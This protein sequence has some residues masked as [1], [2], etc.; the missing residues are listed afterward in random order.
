M[1][2]VLGLFVAWGICWILHLISDVLDYKV[3]SIQEARLNKKSTEKYNK[4][5][6]E[7]LNL[8][9]K[10]LEELDRLARAFADRVTLPTNDMSAEMQKQLWNSNYMYYFNKHRYIYS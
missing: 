9:N 3:P 1:L 7:L 2:F 8:K 10:N 5:P 4:K 6:Y